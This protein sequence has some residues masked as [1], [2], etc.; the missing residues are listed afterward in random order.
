MGISPALEMFQ[1]KLVQALEGFPGVYIIADDV[2][3]LGRSK[4][5]G[6][7]KVPRRESQTHSHQMQRGQHQAEREQIQ[8]QTKSGTLHR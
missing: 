4:T 2:L 7:R 8:D 6:G 3:K 5:R 1:R